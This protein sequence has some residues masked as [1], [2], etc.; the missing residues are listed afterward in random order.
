MCSPRGIYFK[1]GTVEVFY[2]MHHNIMCSKLNMYMTMYILI[3]CTCLVQNDY[4]Y[5]RVH[6]SVRCIRD[7]LEMCFD[8]QLI[9]DSILGYYCSNSVG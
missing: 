7:A 9:I 8:N 4:M 1:D 6:D 2:C 5:I 3:Y